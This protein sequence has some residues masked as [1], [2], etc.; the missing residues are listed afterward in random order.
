MKSKM[1]EEY[2]LNLTVIVVAILPC[3]LHRQSENIK[4]HGIPILLLFLDIYFLKK[5]DSLETVVI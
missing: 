1:L 2:L 3:H 4:K 5:K